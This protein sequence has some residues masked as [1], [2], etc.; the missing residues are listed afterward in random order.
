MFSLFSFLGRPGKIKGSRK[1]KGSGTFFELTGTSF[2]EIGTEVPLKKSLEFSII[3]GIH[4]QR[5]K[6]GQ[7]GLA[8]V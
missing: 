8:G 2:G 4:W 1:I 7:S 3:G 5:N 6:F